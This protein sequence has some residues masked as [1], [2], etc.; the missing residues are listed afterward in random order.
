[1]PH[2][3]KAQEYVGLIQT[4][5]LMGTQEV[6]NKACLEL[7]DHGC[8]VNTA[9]IGTGWDGCLITVCYTEL[10]LAPQR[11]WDPPFHFD[12][13]GVIVGGRDHGRETG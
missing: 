5:S 4:R 11:P 9:V 12:S 6:A 13:R 1:M 7:R 3:H 10:G 8:M 2:G